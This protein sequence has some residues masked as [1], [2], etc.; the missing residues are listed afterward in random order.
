[1][2]EIQPT[3]AFTPQREEARR[4]KPKPLSLQDNKSVAE[5][6]EAVLRLFKRGAVSDLE[7]MERLADTPTRRPELCDKLDA[8]EA[9]VLHLAA[10]EQEMVARCDKTSRRRKHGWSPAM[11]SLRRRLRALQLLLRC[12][13][14]HHHSRARKLDKAGRMAFGRWIRPPPALHANCLWRKWCDEI[15]CEVASQ[16]H[17][18]HGRRRKALRRRMGKWAREKEEKY[19]TAM[20]RKLLQMDLQRAPRSGPLTEVYTEKDEHITSPA[21]V[22]A[23]LASAFETW[24]G[25][26]RVKWYIGK[27]LWKEE[28]APIR[29]WLAHHVPPLGGETEQQWVVRDCW[30]RGGQ[31]P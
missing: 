25:K 31:G 5:Y 18:L 24:F 11:V 9:N 19:R 1:M 22:K 29:R 20:C 21:R 28:N 4:G 12:A 2:L 3:A 8:W 14:K 15:R 23:A 16:L 6:A 10:A 7:E 27:M 26:G 13:E 17:G 30:S